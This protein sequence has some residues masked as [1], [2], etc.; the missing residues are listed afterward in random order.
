[1][2]DANSASPV[3]HY[4]AINDLLV[5]GAVLT[6]PTGIQRVA[7]NLAL[8][9]HERYGYQ[10]VRVHHSAARHASIPRS[11]AR[12]LLATLADPLLRL[13]SHA[14]RVVQE[15]L[16]STA[17]GLLSRFTGA[18]GDAVVFQR[19]DWLLVLG[20]PCTAPRPRRR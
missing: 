5:Y 11:D 6:R 19:G 12:S 14:P 20:A 1:M 2:D 3:Q 16:R 10:S 8:A 17:R 4:I 9:L 7:L 15:R 18:A 13:L